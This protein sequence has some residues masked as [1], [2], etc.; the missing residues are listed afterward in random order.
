MN[1]RENNF[2]QEG[3]FFSKGEYSA[4]ETTVFYFAIERNFTSNGFSTDDWNRDPDPLG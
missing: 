4:P 1:R 3:L 2:P